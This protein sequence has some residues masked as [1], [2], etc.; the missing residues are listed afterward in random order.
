MRCLLINN[1]RIF[2]YNDANAVTFFVSC[3]LLIMWQV[4]SK[5]CWKSDTKHFFIWRKGKLFYQRMDGN[6]RSSS[7][8]VSCSDGAS[9]VAPESEGSSSS[10]GAQRE[11]YCETT[12]RRSLV[13]C[14]AVQWP[15]LTMSGAISDRPLSII[16]TVW[17]RIGIPRSEFVLTTILSNEK[18]LFRSC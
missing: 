4:T 3:L 15:L 13:I 10:W 16:V 12:D 14:L 11:L 1:H 5:D 18:S 7:Q 8:S 17:D 6:S 9:R 2:S